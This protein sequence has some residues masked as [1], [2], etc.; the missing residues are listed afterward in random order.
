VLQTHGKKYG[1]SHFI[2][3]GFIEPSLFGFKH[4]RALYETVS[5]TYVQERLRRD[6]RFVVRTSSEAK[7]LAI[8]NKEV[9]LPIFPSVQI[10]DY[11]ADFLLP[12]VSGGRSGPD[13]YRGVVVE[14]DGPVHFE[15]GKQR[16]DRHTEEMLKALRIVCIRL[17]N[18]EIR[19]GRI[20]R[21]FG[22]FPIKHASC[23]RT[24]KLVWQRIYCLTL[25]RRLKQNAFNRY[26]GLTQKTRSELLRLLRHHKT[27]SHRAMA[28]V[29]E[30]LSVETAKSIRG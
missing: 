20:V 18:R 23:S 21:L 8:W 24:T 14:V 10:G 29:I 3:D 15:E 30:F 6:C 26:F 5:E 19:P 13:S 12:S 27:G 4:L 25:A 2:G 17:D 11:L 7:F 9:G 1:K 22:D 28:N 16:K